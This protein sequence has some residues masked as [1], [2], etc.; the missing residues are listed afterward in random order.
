MNHL[1]TETGFE[2]LNSLCIELENTNIPDRPVKAG[3]SSHA[4]LRRVRMEGVKERENY[5]QV[6]DVRVSLGT[7]IACI[8]NTA[9]VY[10]LKRNKRLSGVVSWLLVV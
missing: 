4:D 9:A 3:Y 10:W 6:R 5:R 2:G 7:C 8:G 1:L